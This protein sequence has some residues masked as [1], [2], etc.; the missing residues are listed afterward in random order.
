MWSE[1]TD[2]LLDSVRADPRVRE[3][4]VTLEA[5]VAAGTCSPTTAARRILEALD[6]EAR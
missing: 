2:S 5:D 3:H 1:V 4:V 6:E